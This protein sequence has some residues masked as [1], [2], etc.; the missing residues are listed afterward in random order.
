MSSAASPGAKMPRRQPG[1]V[2]PRQLH[3][4]GDRLL[5]HAGQRDAGNRHRLR[6]RP[7]LHVAEP[8]LDE[9]SRRGRVDVA[10]DDQARVRRRVV[11]LEERDDVVVAGGGQ[12][13]HVADHRPVIRMALRD[14]ASRRATMS[15]HAVR[16]VLDALPPLVLHDVALGV[17]ASPASSRRADSPCDRTRGTARARARST[18][19]RS[20]SWSGRCSSRRCSVPPTA[21]SA[22]SNT[23]YFD[24]P[25]AHEHQV[26]EQVREAGAALRV[27][28]P[29]RRGT[30]RSR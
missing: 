6:P 25:R 10:G 21:S 5:L 4:I 20:S 26:L 14:R 24:V 9:P 7:R 27:R 2:Q 19:R 30:R 8:L 23:P 11:L 3:A 1:Q 18:A 22:E 28:A 15:G 12:I 13:L 29:S 16:P 17:D